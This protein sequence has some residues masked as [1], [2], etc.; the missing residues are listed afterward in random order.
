MTKNTSGMGKYKPEKGPD[1]WVGDTPYDTV[2]IDGAPD[3]QKPDCF[4]V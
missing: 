3:T 2:G 4:H 1:S